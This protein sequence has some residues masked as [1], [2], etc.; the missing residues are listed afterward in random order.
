MDDDAM[1]TVKVD[2]RHPP[3]ISLFV[4]RV[5]VSDAINQR[6]MQEYL[7]SPLQVA[8]SSRISSDHGTRASGDCRLGEFQGISLV[9]DSPGRTQ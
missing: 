1:G 4:L 5:F 6:E 9:A 8:S 7:Q 2:A 3:H